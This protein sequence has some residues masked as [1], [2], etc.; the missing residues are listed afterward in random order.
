MNKKLFALVVVLMLLCGFA[1]LAE[2]NEVAKI[3]CLIDSGSYIVQ[4]DDPEGDLGWVFETGNQDIAMLYDADLIEDTF[5]ARFDPSSDGEVTVSARHYTGIA[6]DALYT[7]DLVVEGH[8][9]TECTGGSTAMSPA[10][11]ELDPWISGEWTEQDTQFTA[12]IVEKNLERGWNVEAASALTHGAYIFKTTVYYDCDVEGFVYDKGK[13]WDVPITED[14]AEID[15]GEA[16][17]AGSTGAFIFG[18]DT[19]AEATTLTWHDDESGT[20]VVFERAEADAA[21]YD[22]AYYTFEGSGAA[23]KLPADFRPT[24]GEPVPNVFFEAGN[25]DVFLQVQPVEGEFADLDALMEH[26]N[27]LEYVVRSELV[28][29]NGLDLVYSEGGDDNAMIY[30]LVSPEGTSYAFVFIPQNEAGANA[31]QQ[32]ISTIC[33]SDSIPE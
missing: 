12:L 19:S 17:I 30:S 31:I 25:E 9:I 10:E 28:R 33:P 22:G 29:F 14:D 20:D 21:D 6:C 3:N 13:F 26:F 8:M 18:G 23:M 15:L 16:K 4:I 5:V 27:G 2:A 1:A 24:E 11:E 32:I 7:W